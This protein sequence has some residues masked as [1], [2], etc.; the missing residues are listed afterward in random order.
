MMSRFRTTRLPSPADWAR[1]EDAVVTANFWMLDEQNDRLGLD[2]ATWRFAGRRRRDYH[3]ISR[4]SPVDSLWD[5][6][7]LFFDVAG[8]EEVRLY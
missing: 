2:G 7:R 3:S 1:L 6:G 5:L 4:W 8:L